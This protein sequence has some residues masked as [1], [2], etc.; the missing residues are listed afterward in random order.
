[1]KALA[2]MGQGTTSRVTQQKLLLLLLLCGVP[3]M[4]VSASSNVAWGDSGNGGWN[5][6]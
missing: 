3:T 4:L 6:A 2:T 1:M 5:A